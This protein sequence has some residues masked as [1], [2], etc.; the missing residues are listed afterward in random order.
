M[1]SSAPSPAAGESRT[2]IPLPR[3]RKECSSTLW[4]IP[5]P[6]TTSSSFS[7]EFGASSTSR[8][9]ANPGS[10]SFARH[11]ALRTTIHWS[12]LD[13][14]Y[15]VVHRRAEHPVDYQDW[16]ELTTSQQE[17]RLIDYLASDRRRAFARRPASPV[18]V[19]PS[20]GR[21]RCPP[22]DLEHS[23]CRDRRLVPLA[24]A[25]RGA[26]HLRG[27]SPQERTRS[28]GRAGHFATT[29]P[30]YSTAMRNAQRA[31]GVRH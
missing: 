28:P 17:E 21:R 29:S 13:Q 18:A 24:P 3:S 23:P 12:E 9:S 11:P 10:S 27:D 14:P 19:G 30:G 31:T 8:P 22:T 25:P 1:R 26:R 7:A 16:R 20:P 15:Q 5:T 6:E 4:W 2:R